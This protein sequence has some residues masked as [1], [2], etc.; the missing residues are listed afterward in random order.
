M[1]AV[2]VNK[3][4]EGHASLEQT[5]HSVEEAAAGLAG[6]GLVVDL[7]AH[8]ATFRD[9]DWGSTQRRRRQSLAQEDRQQR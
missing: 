9:R 1:S 8:P 2:V 4:L 5:D 7:F 3:D 6:V